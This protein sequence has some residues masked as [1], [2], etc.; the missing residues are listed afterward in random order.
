VGALLTTQRQKGFYITH[1]SDISSVR[2]YARRLT[3]LL[4]FTETQAGQLAIVITEAATNI[5]KHAGEGWVF[6]TSVRRA[7]GNAVEMLALDRGDGITNLAQSL[8]DGVSTAGTA[9]NGLGAIRRLSQDFDAYSIPG[10]GAAFY[11]CVYDKLSFPDGSA[12]AYALSAE[13]PAIQFGSICLPVAGEDECGDDWSIK[14]N[15]D[16]VDILVV[17]GLGHGPEAALAAAA[18]VDTITRA[19]SSLGPAAMIEAMHRAL[20]STRGA[21]AAVAKFDIASGIV[22]FTGIG[23]ISATVIEQTGRKQLVSHNGIVGN[24]MRKVQEFEQAWPADALFIMCSDGIS[25]QWDLDK[26]AGLQYCHPALIAGILFR[27]F[28]RVRDDATVLVMKR[29]DRTT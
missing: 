9:G 17:D 21:A 24:N 27:D 20:M 16:S 26:Y 5:L 2:R 18:A 3:D 11:S 13:E 4:G 22:K 23:N 6:I 12:E 29:N 28:A 14:V 25:T 10:K 15:P 8:R 19:P 7:H 1:T